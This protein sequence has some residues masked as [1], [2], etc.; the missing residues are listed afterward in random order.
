LKKRLVRSKI[1]DTAAQH[2]ANFDADKTSLL[3]QKA[4]SRDLFL[5]NG[6]FAHIVVYSLPR[7]FQEQ[8]FFGCSQFAVV[9]EEILVVR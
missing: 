1:A 9:H 2:P 3:S 6:A 8:F 7:Q 4:L 5:G